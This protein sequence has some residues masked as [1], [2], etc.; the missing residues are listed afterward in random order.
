[1]AVQKVVFSPD[2]N[3]LATA[4]ADEVVRVWD[5]DTGKQLAALPSQGRVEAVAFSPDGESLAV[6][7]KAGIVRIWATPTGN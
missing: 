3:Q 6:G 7:S 5:L 2:G 4:G 1:M